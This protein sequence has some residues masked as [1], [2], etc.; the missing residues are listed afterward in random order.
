V[1]VPACRN[2]GGVEWIGDRG[3]DEHGRCRACREF[4]TLGWL[5]GEWIEAGC[6]IPDGDLAG[7]PYQLTPEMWRFLLRHYR[8]DP[9]VERDPRAERWRLPFVYVRGSQ[10]VRPQSAGRGRRR[11]SRSRRRLRTSRTTCGA[12]CCR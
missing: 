11:T 10:L 5:V 1:S 8:V 9:L 3:S 12:R 6:V 7:E 2:C 4:P